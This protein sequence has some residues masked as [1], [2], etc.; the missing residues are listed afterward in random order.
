MRSLPLRC[1]EEV[2]AGKDEAIE[3]LNYVQRS[4]RK[5]SI[6]GNA[7][8]THIFIL[9][10]HKTDAGFYWLCGQPDEGCIFF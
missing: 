6:A 9:R 10:K 8:S 4:V 2:A 3:T 5:G 1:A 7:R